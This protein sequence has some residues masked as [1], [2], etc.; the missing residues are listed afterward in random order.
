MHICMRL[1]IVDEYKRQ[2][3]DLLQQSTA[4]SVM[5]GYNN[6]YLPNNI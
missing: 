3:A 2:Q 1:D 5:P 6:I 4:W